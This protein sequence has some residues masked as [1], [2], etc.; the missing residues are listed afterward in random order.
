L[1]PVPIEAVVAAVDSFE[2]IED[3]P[4]DK[5]LPSHLVRAEWQQTI[6]HLQVATEVQGD[7]VRIV[8]V[9]I[10]RPDEWDLDGRVRKEPK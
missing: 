2:V 9:Y 10:P 5:Y 1:C 4:H 3:Y 6:F 7:N 8:T